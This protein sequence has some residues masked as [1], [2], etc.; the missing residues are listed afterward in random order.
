MK[1]LTAPAI[2]DFRVRG[3]YF[4]QRSLLSHKEIHHLDR[5]KVLPERPGY[6]PP[7]VEYDAEG[8]ESGSLT[9]SEIDIPL[10]CDN[11]VEKSKQYLSVLMQ[12]RGGDR[13]AARELL[14]LSERHPWLRKT[15]TRRATESRF[16]VPCTS[17]EV[18]S[19]KDISQKGNILLKLSQE[20]YPVPDFVVLTSQ[21]FLDH[22]QPPE[23]YLAEAIEQLEILTLQQLGSATD[24]LVFAIRSATTRY[25]PG[26]MD[27]YLN[28]GVSERTLPC[29]EELYGAAVA[30]RMFLNNLRNLCNAL[31]SEASA[32]LVAEV[33]SGLAASEVDR[34]IERFGDIIRKSDP[35]LLEEPFAQAA[36]IVRHSYETYEQNRDLLL[37]LCRGA[38]RDS[39]PY[40]SLIMQK[41]VCTVR[42][43]ESYA[44][45]LCSRHTQTGSGSELQTARNIFGEEMMTGTA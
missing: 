33:R 11:D 10:L 29:L 3:N 40:P 42:A 27:T 31:D 18:H 13:E 44:G 39:E 36:L 16:V 6:S 19:D 21:A 9:V 41:M 38:E 43:E 37:T 5:D 8:G 26:V 14:A 30:R 28:V 17:E 34:L 24:P 2:R 12:A 45:V 1:P 32:A 35:A 23:S 15:A 25:L 7:V 4:T 20:G 22:S